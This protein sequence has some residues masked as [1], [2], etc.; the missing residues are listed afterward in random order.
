MQASRVVLSWSCT[1]SAGA[2]PRLG[3]PAPLLRFSSTIKKT[4]CQEPKTASARRP[5]APPPEPPGAG[6]L[7]ER[8]QGPG[9]PQ[10]DCSKTHY[11]TP[12]P[13]FFDPLTRSV[14]AP[15]PPSPTFGPPNGAWPPNP[16]RCPPP[17]ALASSGPPSL[18]PLCLLCLA[19]DHPQPWQ[20][21]TQ[22]IKAWGWEVGI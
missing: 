13:A 9:G 7:P 10:G 1:S 19:P 15:D 18:A 16:F 20:P 2:V 6:P 22:P 11:Q 12:K 4:C 21:P 3:Y 8:V 17:L 5:E 14:L